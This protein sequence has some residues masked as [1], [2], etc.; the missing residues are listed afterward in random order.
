MKIIDLSR[1]KNKKDTTK[2]T[3]PSQTN[4]CVVKR[5][6]IEMMS[7]EMI[8]MSECNG[9]TTQLN[10]HTKNICTTPREQRQKN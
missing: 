8:I 5:N 2:N 1:N 10:L 7:A 6:K 3:I 9:G 4:K